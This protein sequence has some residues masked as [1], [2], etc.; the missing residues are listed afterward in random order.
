MHLYVRSSSYVS[1]PAD[2]RGHSTPTPSAHLVSQAFPHVPILFQLDLWLLSNQ[3]LMVHP[4]QAVGQSFL[5]GFPSYAS[6][7]RPMVLTLHCLSGLFASYWI[8]HLA[9]THQAPVPGLVVSGP[10]WAHSR[11]V[12][13]SELNKIGNSCDYAFLCLNEKPLFWHI[14]LK[15]I[16]I[17]SGK[18]LHFLISKC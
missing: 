15:N 12:F 7:V 14:C 16:F 2:P 10:L 6:V 1:V 8:P 13:K 5:I 3:P 9:L 17:S 4:A 11:Y 18:M